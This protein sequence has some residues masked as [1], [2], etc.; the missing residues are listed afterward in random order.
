MKQLLLA[1]AIVV[2]RLLSNVA[3]ATDSSVPLD[4]ANYDLTDQAS[5]KNGA[6]SFMNYC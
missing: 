4:K 2:L 5:L 6:R 3:L 1:I